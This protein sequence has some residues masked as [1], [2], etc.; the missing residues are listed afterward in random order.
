MTASLTAGVQL[1][2]Q[3]KTSIFLDDTKPG[4]RW[5]QVLTGVVGIVL[6]VI[7]IVGQI[8]VATTQ[9]IQHNLH[10][11]VGHL[12]VANKTMGSILDKALPIT[13]VEKI[14]A[15]QQKTLANTLSTMQV[16]N[17]QMSEITATT[18]GLSSTVAGMNTTSASLA[19]GVAGMDANT[20]TITQ[21]LSTLPA[22]TDSTAK[23]LTKISTDST[24]INAE[25]IAIT[26]KLRNYGLPAAKGVRGS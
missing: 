10:A 4:S 1:Q 20:G 16:L 26:A 21:Q 25:L 17:G 7:L 5:G 9:G 15:V 13:Q 3:Q 2:P 18:D 14:V 23:Q 6:A 22:Q 11:T 24:A 8:A 12:A 19:S